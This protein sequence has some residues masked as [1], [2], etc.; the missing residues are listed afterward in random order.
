MG[1][2]DYQN[3]QE[4]LDDSWAPWGVPLR[5]DRKLRKLPDFVSPEEHLGMID[6]E[7]DSRD[8]KVRR[9]IDYDSGVF[10][11]DK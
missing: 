11:R 4:N 8:E 5:V 9:E 6:E 10:H 7:A 2:D 3:Q 1:N